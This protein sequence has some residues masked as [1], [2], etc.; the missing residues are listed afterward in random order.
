MTVMESVNSILRSEEKTQTYIINQI[1]FQKLSP[2]WKAPVII[3]ENLD[4]TNHMIVYDKKLMRIHTNQL[5]SSIP[6]SSLYPILNSF[7]VTKGSG[8]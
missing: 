8:N 1:P 7:F 5:M 2:S 6:I 3:L 4:D